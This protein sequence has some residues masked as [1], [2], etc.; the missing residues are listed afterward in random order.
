M[1]LSLPKTGAHR[2]EWQIPEAVLRVEPIQR[3]NEQK[4]RRNRQTLSRLSNEELLH[5]IIQLLPTHRQLFSQRQ[6]ITRHTSCAV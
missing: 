4:A 2:V 1:E 6:M 3:Q 5:I